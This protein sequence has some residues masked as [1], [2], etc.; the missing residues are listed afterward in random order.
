M[1]FADHVP[2]WDC[3]REEEVT[4]LITPALD[5][6]G[7]FELTPR[8]ISYEAPGGI[9]EYGEALRSFIAS[10]EDEAVL[11]FTYRVDGHQDALIDTHA[12]ILRASR[13][14]VV[15]EYV[16]RHLEWLRRQPMR[17]VRLYLFFSLKGPTSS[18]ARG[19]LGSILPFPSAASLSRKR[20]RD[21]LR[22]LASFRDRLV[23]RLAP[24]G[25]SPREL[26]VEEMRQIHYELA[27]PNR[28]RQ[29]LR[30][31]KVSV[32]EDLWSNKQEAPYLKEYTEGEQLF[33]ET[34]VE[35]HDYWQQEKL[36]RRVCTLKVLPESGT[37]HGE[38]DNLL[39]LRATRRDGASVLFPY[40]LTVTAAIAPQRARKAKL[41]RR[42]DFVKLQR[43]F[44]ARIGMGDESA[45][46]SV[47]NASVQNDIIGLMTELQEL[48]SK[49]VDISVALLLEASSLED[50]N[51]QTEGA[52]QSYNVVDNAELLVEDEGQLPVF[53]S[54]FPGGA[55]FNLRRKGVTSRNVADL[56]PAFAAW[57]GVKRPVSLMR[58]PNHEPVAYDFFD[59][60]HPSTHGAVAAATG[61]GKS[62][63]FGALVADARAAGRDCILLDNGGSWKRLTEALGGQYFMLDP[64]TSICPFPS[65]DAILLDNGAYDDKEIAD[66]I[67]IIQVC[68][69]DH[70]LPAFPRTTTALVSRAVRLA[71]DRLASEP[72]RRPVMENFD[73]ELPAAALDADDLRIAKDLSKRLWACTKGEYAGML[74]QP[75]ALDYSSPM[76][77]FDLAGVSGDPTMKVIAMACITGLVQSRAQTALKQRGVRTVFAVDEAHE[78]LKTDATQEFL[79][80]AYRKFRK[81]G[82][83]CWLIS[84]NF[85]DFTK[86]KCGP[87]VID[88]STI[89]LILYHEKGG[90][91]PLVQA[92]KLT[93]RAAVALNHL[94]R[95]PGLYADF[96]MM[97]G[98][99]ATVIR[100]QVDPYLYW[101]L[102]TDPADNDLRR[103]AQLANP[104]MPDLDVTRHL[105]VEYPFGARTPG[106]PSMA[107]A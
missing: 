41:N 1:S 26:T 81:A 7:G 86:A 77:T 71:Y 49:A 53:F 68:A 107:A 12:S 97:Y 24:A 35:G 32:I 33:H 72:H 36:Y 64:R 17:R 8:D 104:R 44:M 95:A 105:A 21:A 47:K 66:V 99:N 73:N 76:L 106:A 87:V 78:L 56:L 42:S 59:D 69:T 43:G 63:Q 11:R 75:S 96:F 101:L 23:G 55:P 52:R 28:A 46:D 40:W 88:N 18:I 93:P 82:I 31:P 20:H 67:R 4:R 94:S 10:V 84:Q 89:K 54:M 22:A 60:D 13:E 48:H 92:F 50:L 74:N 103:R 58:T 39:Y 45:S 19:A 70:L 98:R 25:L 14:P 29:G 65:R 85:A 9:A 6:I 34:I 37:N 57:K 61:S 5:Y 38:G 15:Q 27:N 100:N 30:A 79:E 80:H 16:H 83:S 62:F 3:S 2:L 91:E 51:A 102:T 90:Y